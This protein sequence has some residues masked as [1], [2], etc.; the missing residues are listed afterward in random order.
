MT[1][2]EDLLT[3]RESSTS[4]EAIAA[5]L[6]AAGRAPDA[7]RDVLAAAD[8]IVVTG[9]GSSYYL[10]Q[11]VAAAA[12]A[13]MNRPVIAAPLSELILR[14][15][16][17]LVGGSGAE[18]A[19][20]AAGHEPVVIISRSGS[21]SEAVSVAERMRAAGHPTVAVTCRAD[22]PLAALADV[23]LVSP[24]GDEAAIVMTRS[25]ASML[26]LL[27]KVVAIV[28]T[29]DRLAADLARLPDRWDEAAAAAG[30]GRRLGKTDWSR[31]AILGGGPAFGVAA[32]WGLKLTETS[33]VPIS[34][35]EPL[36]FR[37]GPISVCEPGMLVVGLVGGAGAAEEVAVVE[38]AARLGADTWLIARDEDEARGATGE[39]S[40]IGGGL[41]PVARLPLL[42]HPSH[43][44][45]LSLALT[46][47]CDPD[48]PRHLGQVVIL[49]L[50]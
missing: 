30:V 34:T 5:A 18:R 37:H 1:G 50:E 41:H 2:F 21:T 6:A 17:V 10:A 12:R 43:A 44:L 3:W 26:A 14:P 47:G 33:Q 20:R 23:T 27:L 40:L 39:V 15:E 8:R 25:F 7:A 49:G 36:E 13:V 48:A 11:A 28:G 16:G 24:A 42:L 38:E 46:R 22:S 31:V 9:A 32:E 35:Y 45:A 4:G 29:D 19:G